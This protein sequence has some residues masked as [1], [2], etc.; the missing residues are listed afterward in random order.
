MA[1][2]KQEVKSDSACE[3]AGILPVTKI[4][5]S[6]NRESRPKEVETQFLAPLCAREA[7]NLAEGLS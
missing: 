2:K 4:A 1:Q 5:V 7:P 3:Y 6:D